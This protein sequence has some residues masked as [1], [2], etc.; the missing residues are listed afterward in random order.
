MLNK[1]AIELSLNFIVILIISI[2]IFGFGVNFIS[3][4]SSQATELQEM[5]VGELDERIGSLICESSDR[6]CVGIDRKT[7]NKKGFGI[8]G[9]KILNIVENE[10]FEVT[11]KNPENYLGY[12]KDGAEIAI[13][14]PKLIV[15]PAARS[16]NI[17]KNEERNLGIGIEV[18]DNAVSGTYILNV[19]IKNAG[20]LYG[21]VQKLYVDVP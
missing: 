14:N 6:V 20:A 2:I 21:S 3:R 17:K 8:F 10:N 15:N 12:K 5:T 16:V 18:P 7:I 19:E 11:V 9:L 13:S 1:S 4:L